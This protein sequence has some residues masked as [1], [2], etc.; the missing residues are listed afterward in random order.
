M[1]HF[2]LFFIVLFLFFGCSKKHSGSCPV[3][4]NQY[5]AR[6]YF[7]GYTDGEIDTI[8]V[9]TFSKNGRFDSLLDEKMICGWAAFDLK[10]AQNFTSPA[11]L[12]PYHDYE[13]FIPTDTITYQI[14]VA[15]VTTIDTFPCD[16][17][18]QCWT[19][20]AGASVSGGKWYG[21]GLSPDNNYIVLQK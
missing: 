11:L 4:C 15:Y 19:P 14:Q 17:V 12:S 20:F 8:Y 1:R 16:Y 9:R 3:T 2:F 6:V 18:R 10:G 7:S 5:E 13:I 21:S